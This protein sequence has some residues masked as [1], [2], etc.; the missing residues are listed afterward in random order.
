MR[1]GSD[2]PGH[3]PPRQHEVGDLA[4]IQHQPRAREQQLHLSGADRRE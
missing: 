3:L 1:H 2:Q 4:R